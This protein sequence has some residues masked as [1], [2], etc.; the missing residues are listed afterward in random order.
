MTARVLVLGPHQGDPVA[1]DV[2]L[3]GQLAP[4]ALSKATVLYAHGAR[5]T[6]GSFYATQPCLMVFLRH[7]ACPSCAA[8]VAELAPHLA[9]LRRA[10]VRV[11]LVGILEPSRL[12][13]F[14]ERLRL[15]DAQVDLVTDASLA[16][17]RAAGLV[18]TIWG[19]LRPASIVAALRLYRHNGIQL[20][21]EGD[22]DINQQGGAL[23]LDSG[24][25]VVLH[26]VSKHLGDR[27][28]MQRLA[29][30]TAQLHGKTEVVRF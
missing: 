20:R 7:A 12:L 8:Q 22:G 25:Q 21:Q 15:E 3:T 24:G 9:T 26:H 19:T 16:C 2:D 4:D 11:V 30:A 10:R 23:L 13:T 28:D 14:G 5:K 17:H 1:R 18:S 27:V 6:V 29:E